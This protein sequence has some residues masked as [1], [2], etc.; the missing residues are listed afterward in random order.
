MMLLIS[1]RFLTETYRNSKL[2]NV[3]SNQNWRGLYGISFHWFYFNTADTQ[4]V[5]HTLKTRFFSYPHNNRCSFVDIPSRFI[6]EFPDSPL[7]C[8]ICRVASQ[9]L[10]VVRLCHNMFRFL[11]IL[12]H[13]TS[14]G[15]FQILVL[16]TAWVK[17]SESVERVFLVWWRAAACP[18]VKVC[19]KINNVVWLGHFCLLR[20]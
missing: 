13:F 2:Q 9:I 10:F 1:K 7:C 11:F 14:E 19:P 5:S 12:H 15:C 16:G 17:P 20:C 3:S 6:F 8:R 18:F 4:K